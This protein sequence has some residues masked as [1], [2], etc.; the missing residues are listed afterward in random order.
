MEERDF[1]KSLQSTCVAI[2]HSFTFTIWKPLESNRTSPLALKLT[3]WQFGFLIC[4]FKNLVS[5][6]KTQLSARNVF[7]FMM[8]TNPKQ[9][10][11]QE[12][13][14]IAHSHYGVIEL[15]CTPN[16]ISHLVRHRVKEHLFFITS[17]HL[18]TC[19]NL[20]L[21][22]PFSRCWPSAV[23]SKWLTS[24]HNAALQHFTSPLHHLLISCTKFNTFHHY[25]TCSW[26]RQGLMSSKISIK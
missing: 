22:Q 19:Q 21:S 9:Q 15:L 7:F 4:I 8:V 24:T 26:H 20:T 11:R 13:K 14:V 10:I 2:L 17:L 23:V 25:D 1:E 18:L 3:Q 5:R 6:L 12:N 16:S